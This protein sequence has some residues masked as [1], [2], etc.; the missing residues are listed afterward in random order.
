VKYLRRVGRYEILDEIGRGGMATVYL[1]RQTDLDRFVALKELSE[2]HAG[3]G[4][5]AQRFLRESRVAGSLSHPNIVTVHDYFEDGGVPF[6][7]M[8]YVERGSLRHYIGDLSLAQIGG[9][10]EGL[11]AGLAAAEQHGIVHRDLKPENVMVAADGS[12]KI[13]DFGIAK[14]RDAL[15][16]GVAVTQTGMIV[17]TPTYM[18]PEQAMGH[19]VGPSTDLYAVGCIAFELLTGRPPFDSS[20]SLMTIMYQHVNEPAPAAA[21]VEPSVDGGISDW[22]AQLLAKDPAQRPQSAADAWDGLEERLL[23]LIGPRWRRGA[24]ISGEGPPPPATIAPAMEPE[25]P[26]P[27]SP[28]PGYAPPP[29]PPT[30]GDGGYVTVGPI[31]V[32]PP[33]PPLVP[34]DDGEYR[35]EPF[36]APL[37]AEFRYLHGPLVRDEGAVSLLGEAE[38]LRALKQRLEHS[39]GG[40]Y[41]VTGFRGVGKTTLVLRALD[42]LRTERGGAFEFLPIVLSVARPL[43]TDQLLFEVVR[44]LFEALSDAGVLETLEPDVRE[45]IVL[46]YARTSMAFKETSSR[47]RE[48]SQSLNLDLGAL[49]PAAFVTPKLGMT[50]KRADS[51]AREASFLA[52]SHADVEH[53][54]LRILDLLCTPPR[55]SRGRRFP[56]WRRRPRPPWRGRIVV[57]LDELDKLPGTEE[58]VATVDALLTGLKNLL[59]ARHV[60]FVFVGGP[61][62]HDA[63]MRDVARGNSVYES[64][65]ACHF[66]VPCLWRC[67]EE[68]VGG[69]IAAENGVPPERLDALVRYFDFKARGIPRLL[70]RELNDLVRWA[71]DGN[72]VIGVDPLDAARVEFYAEVQEIVS[73]F[74]DEAVEHQLLA[75]PIDEDRW[76]LGAYYITDWILRRGTEAFTVADILADDAK[77]APLA[78]ASEERVERFVAHLAEH[79]IVEA[80]WSR[81]GEG[82]LVGDT[83]QVNVYRLDPRVLSKLASFARRNELERAELGRGAAADADGSAPATPWQTGRAQRVVAN[84]YLLRDLLGV[85][86]F[87]RVHRAFDST[88]DRDVAIKFLSP[89]LLGDERALERWRREAQIATQ[90]DHPHIVRTYEVLDEPP[91]TAAIVMELVQGQSLRDALPLQPA[92]A[93]AVAGQLLSALAYATGFGLARFDLKPENVVVAGGTR[94]VIVDLGL[95]KET[96]PQATSFQTVTSPA[97]T[98]ALLVGTP[99]YMAPEQVRGEAVDIRADLYCVALVL[100]ELIAGRHVRHNKGSGVLSEILAGPPDVRDLDVSEP[101][102]ALLERAVAPSPDERF[103]S[104]EEMQAALAATPEGIAAAALAPHELLTPRD[105]ATPRGQLAVLPPVPAPADG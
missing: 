59:T 36:E 56:P 29:P 99:A 82:T 43:T 38:M 14:A 42:E 52:Y 70:L 21:S 69:V 58:G 84:R 41:L 74:M 16:A 48:T 37:K 98:S 101:L 60:H 9:V 7:A 87:G 49:G 18:A 103:A 8:E 39:H 33:P 6:I 105:A 51:L 22:V 85:G 2:F 19:E 95:V 17:G 68:L 80:L 61:E 79:R 75:M 91:D 34:S 32:A 44:R 78:N 71:P 73:A 11:L 76:R 81:D 45:A 4:E 35:A 63:F 46:A 88:L 24:R 10:L 23:E 89:H 47:A 5:L 62:L 13:S 57:V 12:V 31:P 27:P 64:V 94:A 54:F 55:P 28:P 20:G 102:L 72:P 100:Y 65:F 26:Q 30:P 53:D 97:F 3:D 50:R 77:P 1:A 25:P 15:Q 93:V 83:A 86:G 104:P 96:Q 90:L 67:S 66:Y 92:S 40:S